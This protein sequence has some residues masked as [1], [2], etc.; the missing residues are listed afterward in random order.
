M[1]TAKKT[2][3]LRRAASVPAKKEAPAA[4]AINERTATILD[5]DQSDQFEDV[6]RP[7]FLTEDAFEKEAPSGFAPLIQFGPDPENWI[8]GTWIIARFLGQREDVGP[9]QSM[10]YEFEVTGDKGKTFEPASF[11]GSTIFDNK[12]VQLAARP[13]DW[14]YIQYLGTIETSRKMNPAKQFRLA[15]VKPEVL[16]KQGYT[17]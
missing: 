8:E 16:K 3:N 5:R 11:W 13:G 10:M 12:F 7:D 15:V 2:S 6:E 14:I 1:A 4:P 17:V 9:N